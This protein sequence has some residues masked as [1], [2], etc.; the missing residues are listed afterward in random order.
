[1]K[2][3]NKEKKNLKLSLNGHFRVVYR[4]L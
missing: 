4:T 2:G 3:E 1:M